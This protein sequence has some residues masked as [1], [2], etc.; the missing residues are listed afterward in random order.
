MLECGREIQKRYK[1]VIAID[2]NFG[3][4]QAIAKKGNFG[5]YLLQKEDLV[6]KI[7]Q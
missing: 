3:C 2:V 4:P 6:K 1:N 5:S 7:I